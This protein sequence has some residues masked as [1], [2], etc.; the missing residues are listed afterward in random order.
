MVVVPLALLL[1]I[2]LLFV[3]FGNMRDALL[4]F[5]GAHGKADLVKAGPG[6]RP[7]H[8][9][10]DVRALLAPVRSVELEPGRATCRGQVVEATGGSVQL[11]NLPATQE[12]QLDALWAI[13]QLV[14]NDP[15]LDSA[16]AL[17]GLDLVR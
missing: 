7:T 8:I 13:T 17:A 10:A 16:H 2:T 1:I 6:E 9:G 14:W 15:A 4:V 3:T 11:Q 5:S 12:T